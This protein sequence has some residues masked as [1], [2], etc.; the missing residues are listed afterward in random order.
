[1]ANSN[2]IKSVLKNIVA[3][4]ESQRRTGRT[5]ALLEATQSLNGVLVC[6]TEDVVK[7]VKKTGRKAISLS[8]YAKLDPKKLPKT[9]Y[10][11]DNDALVGIAK[12]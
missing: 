1:M 5:T 2:E 3:L 10:I 7:E 4:E 8:S 11:F 6:R 9:V 12:G